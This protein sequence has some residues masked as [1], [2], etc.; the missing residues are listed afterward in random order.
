[1]NAG[2]KIDRKQKNIMRS[3]L[4]QILELQKKIDNEIEKYRRESNIN[5]Y[6]RFWNDLKNK[7]NEN[8]KTISRYMVLKCNR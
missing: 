8:V 6:R 5:E 4:E 1:M 3:Q 7:N 2:G